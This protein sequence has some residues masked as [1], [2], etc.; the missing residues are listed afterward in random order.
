MSILFWKQSLRNQLTGIDISRYSSRVASQA[1]IARS[2]YTML[3]IMRIMIHN[4]FGNSIVNGRFQHSQREPN[5]FWGGWSTPISPFATR[6][7]NQV[8]KE[9]SRN[10]ACSFF[11][12]GE[13]SRV[14]MG[15]SP[16]PAPLSTVE[17]NCT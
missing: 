7:V 9:L 1:T 12:V 14:S 6:A 3:M 8:T 10:N 16:R 13:Q 15:M 4:A 5:Y 2:A 11:A 17:A